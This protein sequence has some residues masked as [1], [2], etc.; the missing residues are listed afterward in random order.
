MTHI[1]A[2]ISHK[3]VL[4]LLFL[5]AVPN[6]ITTEE[7]DRFE[8]WQQTRSKEETKGTAPITWKINREVKHANICL[9]NIPRRIFSIVNK[10]D[11]NDQHNK[12]KQNKTKQ[13]KTN[14]Q[15]QNKNK[16]PTL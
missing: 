14:K 4:F 16:K 5:L 7:I 9:Q 3:A 11:Y 15:K 8:E 12:T 10:N 1:E 13:N 6:T 2:M